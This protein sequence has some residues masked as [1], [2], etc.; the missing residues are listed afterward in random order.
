MNFFAKTVI[1]EELSGIGSC[2]QFPKD[3][4]HSFQLRQQEI[5]LQSL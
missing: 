3:A 4:F 5:E 1:L 2:S